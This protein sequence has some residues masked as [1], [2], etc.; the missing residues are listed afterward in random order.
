MKVV[1]SAMRNRMAP[2]WAPFCLALLL[3]LP[4]C[5]W[6]GKRVGRV[7]WVLDGDTVVL[8]SGEKVRYKGINTPEIAHEGRPAEPF[9][10]RAK[11]FNRQ[12]VEGRR[13]FIVTKGRSRD[14]YGRTLAYLFLPNG[15]M[16]NKRLLEVGLAHMVTKG[17]S[18][19]YWREFLEAQRIAMRR[20]IGLWSLRFRMEGFPVVGNR[21][22]MRFHR[23]DCPYGRSIW[24]GNRRRFRSVWQAFWNGYSPCKKCRPWPPMR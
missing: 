5:S 18:V 24:R 3:L 7:R 8:W 19:P 23:L 16:V 6:G 2:R 11:R 22:S 10:L 9:G 1:S 17:R 13:V 20:G 15:I 12:L 21:K 14:R 4:A